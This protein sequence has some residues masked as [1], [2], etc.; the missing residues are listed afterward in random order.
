MSGLTKPVGKLCKLRS[1]TQCV[2]TVSLNPKWQERKIKDRSFSKE[3]K[4][5]EENLSWN[6]ER[7]EGENTEIYGTSHKGDREKATIAGKILQ[8][9]RG[10]GARKMQ[11]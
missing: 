10:F 1:H 2:G 5:E 11:A 9:A 3:V 6:D 8:P 4:G 7:L